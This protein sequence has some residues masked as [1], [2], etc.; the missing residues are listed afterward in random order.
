LLP[1][2]TQASRRC[3]VVS[4]Q[5]LS[6]D[7]R[8]ASG[9]FGR[10]YQLIPVVMGLCTQQNRSTAGTSI[11]PPTGWRN[12]PARRLAEA[13]PATNVS[14]SRRV[15]LQRGLHHRERQGRLRAGTGAAGST[16]GTERG[17][18]TRA[19]DR[20]RI[21]MRHVRTRSRAT[22]GAPPSPRP[23]CP[24]RRARGGLRPPPLTTPRV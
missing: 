6:A 15:V 3:V 7:G 1:Q 18:R 5:R 2:R 8:R 9:R 4:V 20:K 21:S 12:T 22:I 10:S 24:P 14:R 19:G 11:Y 17:T 16:C 23:G 13:K